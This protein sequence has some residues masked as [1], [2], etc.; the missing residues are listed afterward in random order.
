MESALSGMMAKGQFQHVTKDVDDGDTVETLTD[1]A[2]FLGSFQP[3]KPAELL[4]KPEGQRTWMWWKVWTRQHLNLDDVVID[5]AGHRCR[6][7]SRQDWNPRNG[8]FVYEI[9]E[10]VM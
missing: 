2:D 3:L 9:A 10:G 1:P 6:V 5:P 7:M 8:F 4:I